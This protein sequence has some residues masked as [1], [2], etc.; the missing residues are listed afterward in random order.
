MV[1]FV[2]TTAT[3][4]RDSGGKSAV[5]KGYDLMFDP[6]ITSKPNQRPCSVRSLL[7]NVSYAFYWYSNNLLTHLIVEIS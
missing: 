6:W 5:L 7:I 2:P 1:M 4:R 3:L